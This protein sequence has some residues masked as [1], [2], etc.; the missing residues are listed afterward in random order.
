[1]VS[2]NLALAIPTL[3]AVASAAKNTGPFPL[4]AYGPGIG[5]LP[6]FS[7]GDEVFIGNF[8]HSNSSEAAPIQFSVGNGKWLGSP[9]TTDENSARN[10]TWSNYTF[11]VP[12]P[13]SSS[14]TVKLTNS[15]SDDGYVS[16]FLLYGSFVMLQSDDGFTSLWYASKTEVDDIYTIGWNASAASDDKVPVTLK[17]TP[18]SN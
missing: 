16:N 12:G 1:M 4:F 14:H 9:N 18:P 13:S 17:S 15:T 10:A 5:G 11:A 6:L 8:S 3:V 7:T 2:Y